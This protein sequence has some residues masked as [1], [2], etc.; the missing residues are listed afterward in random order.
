MCYCLVLFDVS[1][2]CS[3]AVEG[4]PLEPSYLI[5]K[6]RISCE[7]IKTEIITTSECVAINSFMTEADII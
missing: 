3:F 1:K 4:W 5:K 7:I 2:F 6:K